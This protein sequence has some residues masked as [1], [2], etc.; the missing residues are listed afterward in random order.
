MAKILIRS[1]PLFLSHVRARAVSSDPGPELAWTR[2]EIREPDIHGG[3]ERRRL[4]QP[5]QQEA[6]QG[7]KGKP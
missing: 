3:N 1:L 7:P 5:H 2:P 4:Q 6:Q